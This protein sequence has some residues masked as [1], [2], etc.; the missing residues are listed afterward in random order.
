MYFGAWSRC[1]IAVAAL[2]LLVIVATVWMQRR[3]PALV[4][5]VSGDGREDHKAL[6]T[7]PI[8]VLG[9]LAIALTAM[10]FAAGEARERTTER[11]WRNTYYNRRAKAAERTQPPPPPR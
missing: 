6:P 7:G 10:L 2:G 8:A 9:P 1:P 3:F 5:R 4:S 11:D